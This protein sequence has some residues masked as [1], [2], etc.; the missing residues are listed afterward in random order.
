MIKRENYWTAIPTRLAHVHL[1][2][3]VIALIRHDLFLPPLAVR[4]ANYRPARRTEAVVEHLDSEVIPRLHVRPNIE[5]KRH[6]D[7]MS[8]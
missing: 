5:D 1:A 3:G 6:A 7:G 2:C 4:A 8:A